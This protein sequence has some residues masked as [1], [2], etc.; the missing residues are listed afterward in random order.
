MN[1]QE[2]NTTEEHVLKSINLSVFVLKEGQS[3]I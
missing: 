3:Y 1:I 2:E